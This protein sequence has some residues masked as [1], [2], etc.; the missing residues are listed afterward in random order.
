MCN[1]NAEIAKVNCRIKNEEEISLDGILPKE[2]FVFQCEA[3]MPDLKDEVVD[4]ED[5]KMKDCE[6]LGISN[7]TKKHVLDD[8]RKMENFVKQ[9]VIRYEGIQPKKGDTNSNKKVSVHI[10]YAIAELAESI[11]CKIVTID[12]L[13]QQN[14]LQ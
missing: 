2:N 6:I 1:V 4:V 10:S 8:S 7:I 13:K 9:D 14:Q 11:G 12:K 5:S 3:R